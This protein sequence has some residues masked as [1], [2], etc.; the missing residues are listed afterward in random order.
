MERTD[1]RLYSYKEA[2]SQPYWI[3]KFND[4]KIWNYPLKL[5]FLVY[6]SLFILIF[7]YILTTLL[8]FTADGFRFMVSGFFGFYFGNIFADLELDGKWMIFYVRDY[9]L[10]YLR[11]FNHAENYYLNKGRMYRKLKVIMKELEKEG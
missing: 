4:K 7:W 11:Y 1:K 6:S 8:P 2:L 9:V 5:S 10:F 3:Q